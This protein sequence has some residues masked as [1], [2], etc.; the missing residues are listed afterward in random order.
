[1]DLHTL[2]SY[3]RLKERLLRMLLEVSSRKGR[4]ELLEAGFLFRSN[5]KFREL[6]EEEVERGRPLPERVEKGW[7]EWLR[8]AVE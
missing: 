1:M 5:Q 2:L 6:W 8:R 4:P 7:R 3:W